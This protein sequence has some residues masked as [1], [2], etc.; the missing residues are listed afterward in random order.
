M[1][2]GQ[3]AFDAMIRFSLEGSFLVLSTFGRQ[4]N[5]SK[6]PFAELYA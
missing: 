3:Q 6:G 4:V 1:G 2:F 5:T